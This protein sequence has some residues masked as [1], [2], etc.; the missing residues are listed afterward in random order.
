MNAGGER[1]GPVILVW[2]KMIA[3]E[4]Q[5]VQNKRRKLGHAEWGVGA[6]GAQLLSQL[7]YDWLC[8][9]GPD[10]LPLLPPHADLSRALTQKA[11]SGL[12]EP[13]ML[14]YPRQGP[15]PCC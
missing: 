3:L 15:G 8:T 2:G 1:E 14:S 10:L 5:C 7:C 4:P 9:L 6:H 12:E 13:W 11:P